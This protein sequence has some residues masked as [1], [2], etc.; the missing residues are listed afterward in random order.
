MCGAQ[1]AR[2]TPRFIVRD[3]ERNGTAII[4]QEI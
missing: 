2:I 1:W 4:Q 3:G